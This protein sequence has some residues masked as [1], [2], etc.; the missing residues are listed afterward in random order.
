M[1]ISIFE[2]ISLLVQLSTIVTVGITAYLL[3]EAKRTR[4]NSQKPLIVPYE[5]NDFDYIDKLFC[6]NISFPLVDEYKYYGTCYFGIKNIGKGPACNLKIEQVTNNW[7]EDG[8]ISSEKI[9]LRINADGNVNV[10]EG[11]VIPVISRIGFTNINFYHGHMAIRISYE[12]LNG[13]KNYCEIHVWFKDVP[14]DKNFLVPVVPIRYGN[15]K[16]M[17]FRHMDIITFR[18]V[19]D[20]GIYELEAINKHNANKKIKILKE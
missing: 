12:D 14:N 18:E 5:A 1:I 15:K 3:I 10:P 11:C 16:K 6:S 2:I 7:S 13:D 8:E 20:T 4:K 9:E 17:K 19:Q